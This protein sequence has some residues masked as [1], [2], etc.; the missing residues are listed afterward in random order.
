MP[1]Q[2]SSSFD[3]GISD[4]TLRSHR[5]DQPKSQQQPV[6]PPGA[7]RLN[8]VLDSF[9]VDKNF[10][11]LVD[12]KTGKTTETY[13]NVFVIQAAKKLGTPIPETTSNKA[14]MTANTMHTWLNKQEN[15]W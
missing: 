15:G 5:S 6:H 9:K 14:P 1:R 13:C 4:T 12:P 2:R 11:P 7:D 10:L 8:R 3:V